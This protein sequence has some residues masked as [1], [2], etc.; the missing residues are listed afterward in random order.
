MQWSIS[1]SQVVLQT[2]QLACLAGAQPACEPAE[3]V[4][5]PEEVAEPEGAKDELWV[6]AWGLKFK[7]V[8]KNSS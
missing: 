4:K 7:V 8:E 5:A 3:A 1:I 2:L 6:E